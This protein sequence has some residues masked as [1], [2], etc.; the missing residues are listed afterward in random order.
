VTAEAKPLL[1]IVLSHPTQY[2]SPWFRHISAQGELKLRVFYLWDFGV[3]PRMDVQFGQT[4]QWDIPLLDGYDSEFV[5]NDSRDPGTHWFGGLDNPR[6]V[7]RVLQ[8][9]P[10]AIM[11]FGY[12]S[13]SHLRLLLSPRLARFPML[14]RGDSHD[15]ARAPGWRS[16]MTR[17]LRRTLFRRFTG[18]LAV[19][20]ANAAY[21]RDSGVDP[22]RVHLV[23]HCVDNDRFQA[24]FADTERQAAQWRADL[25]IPPEA[26]VILFA[27]KFEDKKRPLDLLAAFQSLHAS[28]S[29]PE[30]GQAILLFVGSGALE[31]EMR[32]LAGA[33]VGRQV[34][35]APFQ[36]QTHMPRVYAACD[37]MVLPSYGSGE[38][39]GLAVN[40]AMNLARPCIVSTHVG[41][42][43][44]L[45]EDGQ[46]GWMFEAG[47]RAALAH[48][49]E[50]AIVAGPRVRHDMGMRARARLEAFSYDAATSALHTALS[51][52]AG[53]HNRNSATD[54]GHGGHA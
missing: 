4:V 6:L 11:V 3:Q 21:F 53:S 48:V 20:S 9:A 12:A 50:R 16:L 28:A 13:R 52:L 27:G 29:T 15:L 25:G 41:C 14:I 54:A 33:A 19:G 51:D 5:P 24:A 35:F 43:P 1:A 32:R 49:L 7:D 34:F 37:V 22:V 40:E 18:A 38:T 39:W 23:P 42:G 26:M 2:Y 44:D 47:D 31:P 8:A 30:V 10:D 45:V 17:W 36:N 46:T